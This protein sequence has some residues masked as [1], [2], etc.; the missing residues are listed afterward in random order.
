MLLPPGPAPSPDLLDHFLANPFNFLLQCQ[1]DYGDTFSVPLGDFGAT[2]YQATGNWVFL[3]DPQH[4]KQLFN[5][6]DQ[7]APGGEAN[8]ILFMQLIPSRGSAVIDGVEHVDRRRALSDLVVGKHTLERFNSMI[9]DVAEQAF[10]E[11]TEQQTRAQQTRAQQGTINLASVFRTLS[12]RVMERVTFGDLCDGNTALLAENLHRFGDFGVTPQDKREILD[13]CLSGVESFLSSRAGC[14]VAH[15]SSDRESYTSLLNGLSSTS[16]RW[17]PLEKEQ[18]RDELVTLLLGGADTTATS[19]SW[20]LVWLL[21]NPQAMQTLRQELT[22]ATEDSALAEL[23]IEQLAYLDAVVKESSRISPMLFNSSVRLL[24]QPMQIG[25]YQLPVGTMVANC[26]YLVHHR[27]D[28]YP[29]PEIFK[30]ERFL[31][32]KPN[33]HQWIPFGGGI[34]RCIGM[35]FAQHEIKLALANLLLHYDIE[36]AGVSDQAA[37]QG[38]F[39]GPQAGVPVKLIRR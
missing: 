30:P 35:G 17:Q 14:P 9:L 33:P 6:K 26:N 25:Q 34:R 28:I 2:Q 8:S 38:S 36:D 23:D 31:D 19:M 37:M 12:H 16:D 5:V 21:K 10:R 22:A 20:T 4:I 3:T 1:R 39:F 11:A 24:K 29:E 7:D 27:A 18:L 32:K 13:Q 15:N